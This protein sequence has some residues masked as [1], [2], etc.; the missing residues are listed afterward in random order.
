MKPGAD[1]FSKELSNEV[2][3]PDYPCLERKNAPQL[4][5]RN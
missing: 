5:G 1:A 2:V 4:P 3:L